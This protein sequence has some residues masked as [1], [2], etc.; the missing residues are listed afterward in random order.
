MGPT[1]TENKNIIQQVQ[2]TKSFHKKST[3][4]HFLHPI[5]NHIYND[6][7]KKET[8]NSLR[9]SPQRE[10]WEKALSN[11]WGRLAQGNVYGVNATDTI[12]FIQ[13]T[14]VPK[15]RKITYASFVCD[16]R[17]LKSEPWRVR[18]VVGGDRLSYT[19]ETG[20]PAASLLETKVL[21]NSTISD[22]NRGAR[23]MS[24]DLKD[25]FLATP[26]PI[27]EY[28]KVPLKYF[29]KDI[30]EKYK[31]INIVHNNHIFIKIKKGMY[32]LKQA[33]VLAY[34]NLIT[35]LAPFGY[36]PIPH[37]DSFWR[38]KTDPTKFCLCVDDFGIKYYNK[39]EL[40][41][42]ISALQINYKISTDF[43]GRNY[44]GL[45][46]D[47]DYERG[48]VDISMPGYV[49]KALEKYQHK[50]TTPQTNVKINSNS[51]NSEKPFYAQRPYTFT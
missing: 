51:Q 8:I 21:L 16:H 32:G 20:S 30:V 11:E 49:E 31:L 34:E 26:M 4:N 28:M 25:F 47:W 50:P 46:I 44:C 1:T 48:F 3:T 18:I 9:S 42:L 12:E 38:H 36:E 6:N 33:A 24:L 35:N 37:T 13:H 14:Q 22:A 5:V 10:I 19:N 29:P 40:N 15:Q 7:G 27:E 2:H 39:L 43:S 23:F 45:T 17:P 41:R